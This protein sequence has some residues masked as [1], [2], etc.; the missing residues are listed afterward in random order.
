MDDQL[1]F[2]RIRP[3]IKVPT[4]LS[5][6]DINQRIRSLLKSEDASCEGKTTR[7]YATIYPPLEDQH[8]WSPQLTITVEENEDGNLIRGLYGPKPSVWTMFVFFYSAI[9]F[10]TMIILM[11]GLSLWS[12]G[13]S[14]GILWFVPVLVFL[15]LSQY[16]VSYFGQKLGHKQMGNIHRFIE[17]CLDQ[18]I[19]AH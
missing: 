3:R 7:G 10:A 12:L 13:N 2:R 1:H 19:E 16:L 4:S 17:K 11:V 5:T 8:F 6:D 14:A 18:E 9:G 15:I